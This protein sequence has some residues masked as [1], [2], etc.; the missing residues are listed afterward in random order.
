MKGILYLIFLAAIMSFVGCGDNSTDGLVVDMS[1]TVTDTNAPPVNLPSE[2][3]RAKNEK[4]MLLLEFGSS[5]SCPPC[6]MLQQTVFSSALFHDYEQSNLVF[7]RLDFPQKHYLRAATQA[8][9]DILSEEFNV[10]VFPT[11]FASEDGIHYLEMASVTQQ[12]LDPTNFISVLE[13]IR[14]KLK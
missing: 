2:I 11:F 4:K 12:Q 9:N 5:D 10:S 13:D 8:T 1:R 6:I 14:K 7:V 3:A